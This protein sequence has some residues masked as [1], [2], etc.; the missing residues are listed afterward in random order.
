MTAEYTY[1]VCDFLTGI[2][3]AD[4]PCQADQLPQMLNSDAQA[5]GVTLQ[6]DD[7]AIGDI[8]P[9]RATTPRRTS[10]FVMRNG[11]PAWGG[12]IWD[13]KYDSST[14]VLELSCATV[15]SW[16][17]H[18]AFHSLAA[19]PVPANQTWL[20]GLLIYG[21]IAAA[22]PWN[23]DPAYSS[24]AIGRCPP[25][26]TRIP[27]IDP[28]DPYGTVTSGTTRLTSYETG[29]VVYDAMSELSQLV[30]GVDFTA[31]PAFVNGRYGWSW[32]VGYPGRL[33][34]PYASTGLRFSF[35][36]RGSNVDSYVEDSSGATAATSAVGIG[37][38]VTAAVL[39]SIVDDPVALG[40]GWPMLDTVTQHSDALTQPVLGQ[41]TAADLAASP[42]DA[43][44]ITWSLLG[45][46]DPQFGSYELGDEALFAGSDYRFPRNADGSEGLA[47]L[48]RIVGWTLYPPTDQ[49]PELV[50]PV[51]NVTQTDAAPRYPGTLRNRLAQ[52]ERALVT[53]GIAPRT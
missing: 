30:G 22:E 14:R 39:A 26:M 10:L 49:R 42:V 20:L 17:R 5:Q 25:V 7:K 1:T 21:Q 27:S 41:L 38:Q 34:T 44:A 35:G 32:K 47:R 8:D 23:P 28:T 36:D 12:I 16:Y 2:P 29:K 3:I 50:A 46:T 40:A 19:N 33:Y 48:E 45:D 31:Q 9:D 6:L 51:T 15:E 4:L 43:T 52:I 18:R 53:A 37:G 13:R 11:R 24:G